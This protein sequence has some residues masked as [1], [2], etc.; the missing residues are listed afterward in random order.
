MFI[1]IKAAEKT[2]L[3][4]LRF[5]SQIFGLYG[6]SLCIDQGFSF[7]DMGPHSSFILTHG[8]PC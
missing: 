5:K 2:Y 7:S 4:T 8:P 6:S 3:Y 1:A